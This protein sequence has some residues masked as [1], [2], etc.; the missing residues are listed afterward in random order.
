MAHKI[1]ASQFTYA[2]RTNS[3]APAPLSV[4]VRARARFR[5]CD[6]PRRDRGS[7]RHRSRDAD[8]RPFRRA[9]YLPRLLCANTRQ[10]VDA[11]AEALIKASS[12]GEQA[13][14]PQGQRQSKPMARLVCDAELPKGCA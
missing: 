1:V 14:R 9:S 2:S 8:D 6:R 7:R 4:S 3:A 10:K 11:L 13:A 12:A 5:H